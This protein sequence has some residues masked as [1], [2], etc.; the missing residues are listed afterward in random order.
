MSSN[1]LFCLPDE[2]CP[3][4]EAKVKKKASPRRKPKIDPNSMP[5][6]SAPAAKPF[7]AP[8][9]STPV[10]QLHVQRKSKFAAM[11]EAVEP[12]EKTD[13]ELAMREA[14]VNLWPILSDAEKRRQ[15]ETSSSASVNKRRA[16]IRRQINANEQ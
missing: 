5:P 1:C 14:I 8:A 7:V 13:D 4:H 2:A 6:Q 16:E 12:V 9:D 10:D 3:Q 15:S 11:V